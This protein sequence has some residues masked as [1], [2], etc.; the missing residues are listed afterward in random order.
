MEL[1][2]GDPWAAYARTV[3]EIERD[4]A[5]LVVRAAPHWEVGAWPWPSSDPVYV[6]TAWDPGTARPGEAA[7]RREQAR[8]E[9]ALRSIARATWP[10]R[11][12]DPVTK[13]RDEGVAVVGP[14][15]QAVRGLGARFGQDAIFCWT[16]SAWA[17]VACA[18][19]RRVVTGWAL[20]P[21]RPAGSG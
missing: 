21:G 8:L 13:G 20:G 9:E 14:S 16:P 18:G 3:V 2:P 12:V 10:A 5:P 4:G 15:E 1:A 6:L 17:I 19:P 7:N 11:G